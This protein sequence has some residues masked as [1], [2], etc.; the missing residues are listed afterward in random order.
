MTEILNPDIYAPYYIVDIEGTKLPDDSIIS[1]S[2]EESLDAP[3][4]F[5]ITLNEGLDI[6]TQQFRWLDNPNTDPGKK[7]KI[8]FGYAGKKKYD[9]LEGV[10]KALA[11]GFQSTGVPSLSIQGFDFSHAMQKKMNDFNGKDVKFSDIA[12][13]IAKKNNLTPKVE[14][15]GQK[16]KKV[17]RKKDEKDYDLL[18]RLANEAGFEFFVREKALHFRKPK[19]NAKAIRTYKFRENLVGFSPRLSLS[20]LI[21][22]VVVTG[23]D[24]KTKKSIKEKVTLAQITKKA[25]LGNILKKFIKNADGLEPKKIEFKA[26]KS[27][28]VA[29]KKGEVALRKAINTFITGDL[30][31]IGDPELRVG[32]CVEIE[33]IG[34]LFSG[35]Y[36][37]LTTKHSL[38]SSGYKTTVGIRRNVL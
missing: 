12:S 1:V 37:I 35:D 3:A 19:D 21:N 8:S 9:L 33:G 17:E 30:E 20:Q 16:K 36:Y 27:K 14:D 6:D 31:C 18:R 25:D 11:P 28:E 26:L 10:I 32:N 23:Y 2:V 15:S 7:V 13:E 29:K 4:K 22:E 38:S 34:E 24:E 5:E